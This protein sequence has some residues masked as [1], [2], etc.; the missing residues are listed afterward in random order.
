MGDD[1]AETGRETEAEGKERRGTQRTFVAESD[2]ASPKLLAKVFGQTAQ[3]STPYS[4]SLGLAEWD[5]EN[6]W[7]EAWGPEECV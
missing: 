5:F 3:N 4:Q 2:F 7:P 6:M 1:W